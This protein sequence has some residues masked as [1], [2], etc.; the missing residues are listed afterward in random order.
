MEEVA[1]YV[2]EKKREAESLNQVLS[3][4]GRL[5]GK[6]EVRNGIACFLLVL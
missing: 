3:V 2:N 6:F 5:T 1:T 4:Q